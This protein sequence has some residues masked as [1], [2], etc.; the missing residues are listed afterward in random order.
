MSHI[1]DNSCFS[2]NQILANFPLKVIIYF[3]NIVY[4][5]RFT[6]FKKDTG[7]V[8]KTFPEKNQDKLKIRSVLNA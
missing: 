7:S 4:R 6:I 8:I 5:F 2:A 3:F 1:E